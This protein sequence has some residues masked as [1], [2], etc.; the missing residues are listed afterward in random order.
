MQDIINMKTQTSTATLNK[1]T[2]METRII[3]SLSITFHQ[4]GHT[5]T[6]HY[7]FKLNIATCEG[8]NTRE[9]AIR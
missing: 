7:A 2:N 1:Q 9:V 8:L 5:P 3:C 6:A 4:L